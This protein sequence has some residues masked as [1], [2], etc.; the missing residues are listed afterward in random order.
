MIVFTLAGYDL[1]FKVVRDRFPPQK[2]VTPRQVAE[3][4]QLVARHDRAGRLVE[5]Q[6]F[7][8][9]KLPSDRFDPDVLDELVSEASRTV[10]VSDGQVTFAT[11]YLERRVTPLDLY[12]RSADI[13]EAKRAIIDYGAAI[14]NLAASNIFPGTCCSRTLV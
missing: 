12:I 6:R 14:K 8:D 1:V 11:I 5:A 4:Y 10:A 9:L 2:F 13:D 3:R 7:H